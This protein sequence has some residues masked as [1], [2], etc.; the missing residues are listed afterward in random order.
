MAMQRGSSDGPGGVASTLW[1]RR[2]GGRVAV[3]GL[4][5]SMLGAGAHASADVT[6]VATFENFSVGS[7]FKPTF[8]DSL[9]GV[10]FTNSTGPTNDFVVN[11]GISDFGFSNY[12]GSG[13]IGPSRTFQ[14]GFTGVL[15]TPA[16]YV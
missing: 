10:I 15:P 8:T 6:R 11:S 2:I 12:L 5:A 9:S 7:E 14:F 4:V 16:N 3:A 13:G 1:Q